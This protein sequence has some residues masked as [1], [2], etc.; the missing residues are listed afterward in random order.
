M[1]TLSQPPA[2]LPK[3]TVAQVS[4]LR[5]A[6]WE[7]RE[8]SYHDAAVGELNSLVR[9]Y[10]GLA[11]HAVRRA[12]YTRT[13]EL[14]KVYQDSAEDIL[15]GIADRRNNPSMRSLG[16]QSPFDDD[17]GKIGGIPH[18]SG[19]NGDLRFWDMLKGWFSALT[20]RAR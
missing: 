10:N 13:A 5:D 19:A 9:R 15:Q 1:L 8:R 6:E 7:G 18:G 2:S 17:E 16:G 20:Q 4:A 3:L 12:Y 11:P 14:E